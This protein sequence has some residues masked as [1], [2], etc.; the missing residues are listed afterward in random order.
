MPLFQFPKDFLWGVSTSDYQIEGAASKYGKG[1]TY[2]DRFSRTPGR[3]NNNDS[4]EIACDHY[5]KYVE[6]IQ[7]MKELG[8]KSYRMSISWARVFPEGKGV[9]N[10]AGMDFY[11]KV[12]DELL[13]N[14]II[15][16]ITLHHWG[17]PQKLQDIGGWTNRETAEYYR[18]YVEYIFK[19]L[20]DRVHTWITHNEP[21]G[22]SY[23]GYY[24]GIHAPGV[25]DFSA[26]ILATHNILLS[27]GLAVNTFRQTG[28]KGEIGITLNVHPTFPASDNQKD[29]IASDRM[30]KYFNN[31]F[32]DA[33]F[34]GS[35]PAG[36][37][38]FFRSKGAMIPELNSDDL[39][40]I[41]QPVDFLGVNYY[42]PHFVSY[43][44]DA[45]P[46]EAEISTSRPYNQNTDTGWEI[47]PEGLYISLKKLVK[48]YG[49]IK[50][51]ITENGAAFN[52]LINRYGSIED[53]RRIDFLHR[54]ISQVHKSIQEG[55]NIKGYY[56]WSLMDNF[57]WTYG[58]SQRFGL[59]YIDYKTLRR[60]IKDSGYWYRD[61]IANNG[62]KQ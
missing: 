54:H 51:I 6:D 3:I 25:R 1:E 39:N 31:W 2:W 60:Q 12:I 30:D 44:S 38:D 23:F 35:F 7:I 24:K 45:W 8:I 59:V 27:H 36:L 17:F 11:N 26:S 20:G 32:Q 42:Y 52:D 4:A 43:N 10:N 57:E 56:I 18:E 61:L 48:E 5:H 46:F 47:F 21:I 14:N 29:I 33:I 9:P 15:P 19:Q 58:Y 49:D 62:I 37:E 40:L 53:N 55:I 13:K 50:I 28:L 16:I 22:T 34:K 41:Q